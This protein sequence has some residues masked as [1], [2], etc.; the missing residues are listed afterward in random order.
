[1]LRNAIRVSTDGS[2]VEV[3]TEY[4][5]R[6]NARRAEYSLFGPIRIADIQTAAKLGGHVWLSCWHFT[7]G[8]AYT[9]QGSGDATDWLSR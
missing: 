9:T 6:L 3:K 2:V 1:M 7:I 8:V 5:R 4:A